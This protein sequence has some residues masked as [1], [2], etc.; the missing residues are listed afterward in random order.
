[1]AAKMAAG[2]RKNDNCITNELGTTISAQFG[3][4]SPFWRLL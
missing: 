1:M 2:A 3:M 4:S